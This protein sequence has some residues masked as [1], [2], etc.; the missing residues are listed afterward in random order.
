MF[1]GR[2]FF[3]SFTV[4]LHRRSKGLGR[5]AMR[6][7]DKTERMMMDEYG[8]TIQLW[9]IAARR[10][11]VSF[12]SILS[13]SDSFLTAVVET[14]VME[15]PWLTLI[16]SQFIYLSLSSCACSKMCS[17]RFVRV[18]HRCDGCGGSNGGESSLT[19]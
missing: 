17:S 9:L 7:G 2:N 18:A 10:S 1:K 19:W 6:D 8:N 15:M 5:A 12:R 14:L 11:D 16:S 4:V 3:D 13:D